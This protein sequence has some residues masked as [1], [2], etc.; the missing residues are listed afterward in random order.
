MKKLLEKIV[1]RRNPA[2]EF[3]SSVSTFILLAFVFEQAMALLRGSQ[4]VLLLRQPKWMMRGRSVKLHRLSRLKWGKHVKLGDHVILDALG[5]DGVQLGH[6]VGIGAYSRLIVATSLSSP[7]LHIR[8]GNNSSMGE[9][10]YI[11]GA[12]GV[13]IGT[14][15]IIGQYFSCH[16]ENHL[17]DDPAIPIRRQG[18]S[19]QGIT[20]G[21]NCWIGSKVTVL[22]GVTIGD[23]C[24][25][26]AGAVVNKSFPANSV[27]GGVPARLIRKRPTS[28]FEPVTIDSPLLNYAS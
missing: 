8:I 20:I 9:F 11:G 7:G 25:I 21:N 22:D 23:G 19:R 24:V 1:Q 16:P 18:V 12:G 6:N 14:D 5:R 17:F 15:C 28:T 26:A 10:A 27:I 4:T 13:T 3:H 2:F